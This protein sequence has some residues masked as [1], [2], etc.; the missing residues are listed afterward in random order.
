MWQVVEPDR[1]ILYMDIQGQVVIGFDEFC[2]QSDRTFDITF[3]NL[4]RN[5][6]LLQ[7][8]NLES[9]Y[10]D[11][12]RAISFFKAYLGAF[13]G[14]D[15]VQDKLGENPNIRILIQDTERLKKVNEIFGRTK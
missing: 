14:D 4:A 15:G 3:N 9:M 1:R 5:K 7:A 11:T 10:S 6:P 2:G 12:G 8:L 13:Y